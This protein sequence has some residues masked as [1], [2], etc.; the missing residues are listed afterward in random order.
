MSKLR[1]GFVGVG[2][3]G[4]MAHLRNYMALPECE[5]VALSELR[6]QLGQEVARRYGVPKVFHDHKEMLDQCELDGIVASQPYSRH[7]LLLPEIL[8]RKIPVFTE[9]PLAI[10]VESGEKLATLTENHQCLYMVGYHKRSDPAMEHAVNVIREWK[11]TGQYGA[12]RLVRATMPPGDWVAG[13]NQGFLD[14]GE[15]YPPVEWEPTP[16]DMDQAT[17]DEYNSFVN[18]YIHQVNALRFLLQEPYK[19]TFASSSGALL[20]GESSTGITITLEM[21]PY[22][23]RN[24]WQESYLVG[25]E[26]GYVFV[27]LPAPLASQQP[28]RVTILRDSDKEPGPVTEMPIL[29]RRH[30]MLNQAANFLAA[31]RGERPAPCTAK[32]ALEDLKVAKDYI[33]LKRG[34]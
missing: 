13:G 26:R 5:V 25:F 31:I 33:G 19:V 6:P 15:A 11:K 17:F 9:K 27:E 24:D 12:M 18:Y 28:G 21:A 2:F 29:P 14:S 1:I 10:S 34:L 4:Q 7:L 23:T 30:A 22:Q 32:E 16:G 8:E 3:M 20:A